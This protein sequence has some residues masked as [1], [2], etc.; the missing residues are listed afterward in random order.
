MPQGGRIGVNL[1]ERI[2]FLTPD[3]TLEDA[4]GVEYLA[5]MARRLHIN[6]KSIQ[7]IKVGG[8]DS[9]GEYKTGEQNAQVRNY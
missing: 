4:I 3:Y 6:K 2:D 8:I 5:K 1:M 7:Y 9:F